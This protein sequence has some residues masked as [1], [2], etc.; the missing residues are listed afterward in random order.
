MDAHASLT[1]APSRASLYVPPPKPIRRHVQRSKIH[2]FIALSLFLLSRT[3]HVV[4][5]SMSAHTT[6][7]KVLEN[8]IAGMTTAVIHTSMFWLVSPRLVSAACLQGDLRP[9]CIGVYKVPMDDE[10]LPYVGTPEALKRFAPDLEYVPPIS[11]PASLSS[12]MEILKTQQLAAND[13]KD[14]VSAGRLEEAG[15]KLLNLIPRVTSSGRY[16]LSTFQAR[17]MSNNAIDELK[18]GMLENQLNLLMGLFGDC[19]VVIG[20]GLR[21]EMGVSAVAQLTILSSLN[22]ASNAL[23][24][25]LVLASKLLDAAR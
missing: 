24:D 3:R 20:Q 11:S 12:A 16:V 5:W 8:T 6:R 14:V 15:I 7:R 13:I 10:V 25:F 17:T 22:D 9:E 19:D 4:P 23:D 2:C 18:V 21:G 1:G